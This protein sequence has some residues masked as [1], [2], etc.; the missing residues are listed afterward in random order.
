MVRNAMKIGSWEGAP[1]AGEGWS[2]TAAQPETTCQ[3]ES[4]RGEGADL[5]LPRGNVFQ[6]ED[7]AGAKAPRPDRRWSGLRGREAMGL[8]WV[9]GERGHGAGCGRRISHGPGL[10]HSS[11]KDERNVISFLFFHGSFEGCVCCRKILQSD[12]VP[13]KNKLYQPPCCPSF[14]CEAVS[15]VS[16]AWALARLCA[17][18]PLSGPECPQLKDAR[19]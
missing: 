8:E 6:A 5:Q 14:S 3:D 18:L 17:S 13:M 19:W 9:Q 11:E 2:G 4:E 12:C 16:A 10:Q 1:E 15:A 7:G